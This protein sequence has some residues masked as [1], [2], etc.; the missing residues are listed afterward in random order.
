MEITPGSELSEIDF[1]AEFRDKTEYSFEAEGHPFIILKEKDGQYHF[2]ID[3]GWNDRLTQDERQHWMNFR[4]GRSYGT[5]FNSAVREF[6]RILID[7]HT[8]MK[9]TG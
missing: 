6:C 4:A 5:D 9:R 3:G 1:E 7:L 8:D 2:K